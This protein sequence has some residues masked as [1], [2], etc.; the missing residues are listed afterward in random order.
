[1]EEYPNIRKHT[2]SLKIHNF[3]GKKNYQISQQWKIFKVG[4]QKTLESRCWEPSGT[5]IEGQ[6]LEFCGPW[7]QSSESAP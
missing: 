5:G 1:M 6:G 3:T 2:L 4:F 7:G